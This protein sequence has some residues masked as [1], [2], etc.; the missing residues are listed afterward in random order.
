MPTGI[1]KRK[2]FSEEHRKKISEARKGIIYSA[3]VRANISKAGKGRKMP[4]SFCEK[5]SARMRGS[6]NPFWRGGITK[7]EKYAIDWTNTLRRSIRERDNYTCQLCGEE[8]SDR[9]H[10]VHHIDYKKTNNNPDNLVTLCVSCHAKTGVKRRYWV[11]FFN[12]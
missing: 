2:P 11:N 6:N 4:K 1:Y 9:A 8:Q 12:K 7:K 3:E 10:A 5:N